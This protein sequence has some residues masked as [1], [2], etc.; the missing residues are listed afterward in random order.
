MQVAKQNTSKSFGNNTHCCSDKGVALAKEGGDGLPVSPKAL[1]LVMQ[2]SSEGLVLTTLEKKGAPQL[3]RM[4]SQKTCPAP[5]TTKYGSL[6]RHS[7]RECTA[8]R[9]A[10]YTFGVIWEGTHDCQG[11][12]HMG[13]SKEESESE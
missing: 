4:E 9:V 6:V 3:G 2:P 5:N 11:P 12:L 7:M 13:C 8:H 1:P 10:P